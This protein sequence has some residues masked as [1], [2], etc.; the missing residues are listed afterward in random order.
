MLSKK[1]SVYIYIYIYIYWQ[2]FKH[3]YAKDAHTHT[4]GTKP[5]LNLWLW[6]LSCS[7]THVICQKTHTHTKN[8]AHAMIFYKFTFFNFFPGE[9][10]TCIYAY[11]HRSH[12]PVSYVFKFVSF[13]LMP[14]PPSTLFSCW[15]YFDRVLHYQYHCMSS[16]DKGDAHSKYCCTDT[17]LH[18][19]SL[20]FCL[21][22]EVERDE[23]FTLWG[24]EGW[25]VYLVR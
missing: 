21:P 7:R 3:N 8:H 12:I 9:L 18:L 19:L 20:N 25:D 13:I 16:C 11:P 14:F 10:K 6:V 5:R 1:K 2:V 22:C 17:P 15:F 24:R 23:M 4:K